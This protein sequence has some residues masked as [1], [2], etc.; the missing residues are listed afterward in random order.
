MPTPVSSQ[1]I[2]LSTDI[3]VL[4]ID[5]VQKKFSVSFYNNNI[6]E[7]INRITDN[8]VFHSMTVT[9]DSTC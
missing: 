4:T 5:F 3:S 1:D 7:I 6:I 2:I 9:N 8:P